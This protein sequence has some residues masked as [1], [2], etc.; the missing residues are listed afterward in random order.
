MQTERTSGTRQQKKQI[1]T[2]AYETWAEL[3]GETDLQQRHDKQV[4]GPI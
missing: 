1:D 4:T 3:W 2:Q